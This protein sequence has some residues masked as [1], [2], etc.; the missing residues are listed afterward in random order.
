MSRINIGCGISPTPGWDNYDN[1]LSLIVVRYPI[2][3]NILRLL[4][5]LSA[6]QQRAIESH[7]SS[8]VLVKRANAARFIPKDDKSVLVI[9]ASHVLEHMDK[10]EAR[11]FLRESIRVLAPGGIIRISVPDLS[12]ITNEYILSGDADSFVERLN[13][14][15][16][17]P[18]TWRHMIQYLVVG[19]RNHHWMYDASS[20]CR[21]LESTG[22]KNPGVVPPGCTTIPEPGA[23]NLHELSDESLYVEAHAP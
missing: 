13:I 4:G 8:P 9:Y 1:S 20:L 23:L 6:A 17:K 22:F 19:P 18:K 10:D 21:L 11:A 7:E 16:P 15:S 2:L 5:F 14:V 12:R 3:K